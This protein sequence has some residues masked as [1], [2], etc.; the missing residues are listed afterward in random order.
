MK[1]MLLPLRLYAF[2][3]L[4]RYAVMPLC[5]CAS[6]PLRPSSSVALAKEDYTL[7]TEFNI[8]FSGDFLFL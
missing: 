7:L 5:L 1:F 8:P 3:P 6:A 2:A 4:C